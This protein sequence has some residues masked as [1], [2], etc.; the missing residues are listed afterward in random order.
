MWCWHRGR[1]RGAD[2]GVL[3]ALCVWYLLKTCTHILSCTEFFAC[4]QEDTMPPKWKKRVQKG[5]GG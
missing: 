1:N 4:E 3:A 5:V 2:S